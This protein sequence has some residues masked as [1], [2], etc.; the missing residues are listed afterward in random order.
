MHL[1]DETAFLELLQ[2][3][4]HLSLIAEQESIYLFSHVDNLFHFLP[5]NVTKIC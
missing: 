1:T 2:R 4:G 5:A 3:G